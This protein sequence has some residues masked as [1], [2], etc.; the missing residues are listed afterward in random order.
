[1]RRRDF[2]TF[3]AHI[4]VLGCFAPA[5]AQQDP[6]KRRIGVLMGM[7]AGDPMGATFLGAF[8]DALSNLSWKE[9]QNIKVEFR[10]AIDPEVMRTLASDLAGLEPEIVLTF[11]TPATKAVQQAVHGVPILFV[12]VS[13]PI[14]TGFVKSFS[15]PGGSITGFTNF[16][17]SMGGKWVE[18][19]H[20]I[21]PAVERIAMLFDPGSAN[22]GASGGIYL[23]AMKAAAISLGKEF[24]VSP[25]STLAGIDDAFA[26]MAE[27]G[28]GGFIV[29]PNVFTV[30]NQDRILEMAARFRIPTL[31]PLSQ[32]VMAGGL[33]SYGIDFSDQ[34]R[35]A[36]AY[37]NRILQGTK[38]ADLPVQQP[39]KF[40]LAINRKTAK[41][42]G[43]TIPAALLA[44]AD[45]LV[46]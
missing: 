36:G 3:L 21:A 24:T 30:S 33:I 31:Y 13:D 12:A 41:E 34:F 38:P 32:F 6:R 25:V 26:A 5:I 11:T 18:L 27:Q 8:R 17:P 40:E 15:H 37:A 9:G 4:P 46:D 44:T 29:M 7:A 45:A 42:L 43:L 16:E 2:V 10:A 23:Q 14:G 19:I 20:E 22:Q 35:L 1:M 39:T 28:S